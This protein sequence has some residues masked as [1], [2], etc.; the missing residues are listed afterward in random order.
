MLQADARTQ[1]FLQDFEDLGPGDGAAIQV[2]QPA[3]YGRS[4][5]GLGIEP[6]L[7]DG[8]YA[9]MK[10]QFSDNSYGNNRSNVGGKPACLRLLNRKT[11]RHLQKQTGVQ[12]PR[13]LPDA[14]HTSAHEV[15]DTA[16]LTTQLSGGQ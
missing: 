5:P 6:Y 12:N 13:F 2:L 14:I 3:Q 16:S 8:H 15:P 11:S 4:V 10:L 9:E 1:T 7:V